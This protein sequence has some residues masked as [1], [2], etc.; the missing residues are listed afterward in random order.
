MC[1]RSDHGKEFENSNFVDYCNEHS[2]DHNVSAPRT[3][4]QNG[5]VERKDRTLE[6]ITGTML[7]A[8]GLLRNFLGGSIK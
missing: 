5:V 7:T 6:D 2:V 4:Q 8:S 1:L 3:P